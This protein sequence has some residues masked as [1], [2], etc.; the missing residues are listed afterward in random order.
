M[1]SLLF[2]SPPTTRKKLAKGVGC[3]ADAL[4]LDLGG[5]PF[6]A[7][8]KKRWRAIIACHYI[9]ATRALEKKRAPLALR[10]ASMALDTPHLGGG[11]GRRPWG[12]GP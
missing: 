6:S 2:I 7:P 12:A 3:G 5:L 8:R 9:A 11:P 10:G 1:R 4:I